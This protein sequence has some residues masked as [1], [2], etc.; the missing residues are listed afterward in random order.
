MACAG[1]RD[2]QARQHFQDLGFLDD[3]GLHSGRRE[4]EVDDDR[5]GSS[6]RCL[7]TNGRESA[8]GLLLQGGEHTVARAHKSTHEG[9]GVLV[10][11]RGYG[12]VN[13]ARETWLGAG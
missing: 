1:D 10:V 7:Q 9:L 5:A 2:A 4:Q 12:D 3:F 6:A 13:V 11:G 8:S